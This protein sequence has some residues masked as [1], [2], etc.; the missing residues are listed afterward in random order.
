MKRLSKLFLS[1]FVLSL[2][3][4][5]AYSRADA[6]WMTITLT[7]WWNVVS[8]PALLSNIS[9]SNWWN[10]ISFSYLESG[11]WMSVVPTIDTMKPLWWFLVKNSN[12]TDV[13]MVLT[14]KNISPSESMHQKNVNIWRNLLWITTMNQPFYSIN[15]RLYLD[16]TNNNNSNLLNTINT[17]YI[18]WNWN[19][20]YPEI[21]E[22]YWI[23]LSSNQLYWW[24]NNKYWNEKNLF[25]TDDYQKVI[26]VTPWSYNIPLLKWTI[27]TDQS[28]S[29]KNVW[30]YIEISWANAYEDIRW[31]EA[32]WIIYDIVVKVWS[33]ES[34]IDKYNFAVQTDALWYKKIEIPL[35]ENC[36]YVN[37][38]TYDISVLLWI[39]W[40]YATNFK[41][42]MTITMN[43]INRYSFN[44][45]ILDWEIKPSII[46][47][48][49][50]NLPNLIVETSNNQ[51]GVQISSWM[52]NFVL[53]SGI[54]HTTES[55]LTANI[56]LDFDTVNNNTLRYKM[57]VSTYINWELIDTTWY[58]NISIKHEIP[59]NQNEDTFVEFRWN[60]TSTFTWSF[61][62]RII[63][64]RIMKNNI[65]FI[66]QNC[67]YYRNEC[68][69]FNGWNY[70][71]NWWLF[72]VN[73]WNNWWG[74]NWWWSNNGWC[75]AEQLLACIT[76]DDFDACIAHCSYNENLDVY[77]LITWTLFIAPWTENVELFKAKLISTNANWI[78]ITD[79]EI[80]AT[81]FNS[82]LFS[83]LKVYVDG[84]QYDW[85]MNSSN[86]VFNNND[87]FD[88]PAWSLVYVKIV[89]DIADNVVTNNPVRFK[90]I[91]NTW[92]DTITNSYI[93]F[94]WQSTHWPDVSI[95]YPYFT[96]KNENTINNHYS[97]IPWNES[98][99]RNFNIHQY[100]EDTN[101]S[102]IS[103]YYS[104]T[105]WLSTMISSA[106]LESE[107]YSISC[108]NDELPDINTGYLMFNDFNIL[109][110]KD[111]LLNLSLEL[112]AEDEFSNIWN[113]LEFTLHTWN[114]NLQWSL[115]SWWS[116][117]SEQIRIVWEVPE[118]TFTKDWEDILMTIQNISKYGLEIWEIKYRIL[119]NIG[120]S[121]QDCVEWTA[122]ILDS[123]NGI[124]VGTSW[125]FPWR[126]TSQIGQWYWLIESNDN[127][128]YNIHL[129]SNYIIESDYYTV[130]ISSL[131]YRYLNDNNITDWIEV[132][133][134]V[135]L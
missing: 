39:N 80:D 76:A 77:S 35:F 125:N 132:Q 121:S 107:D 88:I 113:I 129:N 89:W 11:Q 44:N 5:G 115:W 19:I 58:R 82:W 59:L 108:I 64:N 9:F 10:G 126:I 68:K 33:C 71:I 30:F 128:T 87:S 13:D 40:E 16:F 114:I 61:V 135:S 45:S 3:L 70:I 105:T 75:S 123:I 15:P 130:D 69:E 56:L 2:W 134:N 23:F 95:I 79:Y 112:I 42:G 131:K 103:F 117:Q 81:N 104:G 43:P 31:Y 1:I 102:H 124:E 122:V 116:I 97:I 83:N 51:T 92:Y 85:D 20:P 72:N 91:L 14:Y 84:V 93:N 78:E 49:H 74:G 37:A 36:N 29:F 90:L 96:L 60:F 54:L 73:G 52:T 47:V 21:W 120:N 66:T 50:N 63:V 32:W 98:T 4:V 8:T 12:N 65:N 46:E 53:W 7:P 17:D 100:I 101:L 48:S 26:G 6:T 41:T 27:T 110:Q 106:C 25:N 94:Y 34:H 133:Y 28:M 22:A 127:L 111:A 99:V 86:L 24:S 55:W 119:C 62:P 67:N 109:V 18:A 57:N 38:W 118:I